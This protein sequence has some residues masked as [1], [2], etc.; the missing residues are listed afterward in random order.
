MSPGAPPAAPSRSLL[1]APYG[2]L[3]TGYDEALGPDGAYRPR[4][5]EFAEQLA[6]VGAPDFKRRWAESQ[7]L[8]YENGLAYSAYGDPVSNARPWQLDPLPLIVSIDE[9]QVL[10]EGLAQRAA[11]LRLTLADLLGKQTLVRD[12]V[13]PA[14][15]LFRHPGFCRPFHQAAPAEPEQFLQ[16]Y[17]ADVARAEDGSWWVLGDRTES[18]SGAGFVIENRVVVSRMLPEAFRSM[19]VH[20]LAPFFIAVQDRLRERAHTHR[21]NPRIVYLSQGPRDP[22]FFEDA[23]LARYLGYTLVEGADLAVRNSRVWL[24]TLEGLSP[25]DVIL[26]RPNSVA[27]DP[28]ELGGQSELGAAGLLHAV[29]SGNLSILNPLGSGLVESAVFMAFMPRLAQALLKEPLKLPGVATWWCGEPE[30]LAYVLANLDRLRV[31]HAYRRRGQDNTLGRELGELARDELVARIKDRPYDYVGQENVHRSTAPA[32]NGEAP[33]PVHVVVRA[34]A[35]ADGK[36]FQVLEGGLARTSPTTAASSNRQPAIEGSKDL[37]IV[38]NQKVEPITLMAHHDRPIALCRSGSEIPSRVADNIYWLGRHIER[39][40]AGARLLRTIALRLSS[41]LATPSLAAMPPLWRAL[42][43][44]GQIEPGFVLEGLRQRLPNLEH[45]LPRMVYDAAQGGSLAGVVA[46]AARLAA[47]VRD[48]ISMDAWRV[49]KRMQRQFERVDPA[50]VDWTTLLNLSNEILVD[51]AALGG[52]VMESMTRTQLF[53]FLDIGRRLERALQVTTLLRCCFVGDEA[54][55]AELLESVLEIGDSIMTYRSR[56]LANF[57]LAPVLDL[58]LTDETNPRSVAYQLAAL[59]NH[60]GQLP[61]DRRRPQLD[62]D[63][64]LIMS[65]VHAVR[66]SDVEEMSEQRCLGQGAALAGLLEGLE[67]DLP[68]LS[69][70]I[71][72][73]YLVLAGPATQIATI[74]PGE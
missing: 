54:T 38:G 64:Q 26:R 11:L 53:R 5:R 34:F 20:R 56:Y 33:R 66:M 67:R 14:E 71:A 10:A 15:A 61:R 50:A 3:P 8:I 27:C 52:M 62:D 18:P 73:R 46:E 31:K 17:A 7:R 35:V 13:L 43:E 19:Y 72:F 42:A 28:L 49:V 44:Q 60:A 63:Q 1:D 74:H 30:S 45:A 22:D 4:W 32:W 23:Y 68:Q 24:K 70:A 55:S 36:S 12:G 48:R 51:V 16:L 69:D 59:E 40:D 58:L 9:W 47:Q 2:P 65:M 25:V 41:E 37:W 39:A 29:R 6:K 21:D 57:Q